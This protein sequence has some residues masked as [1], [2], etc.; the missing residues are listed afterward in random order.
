MKKLLSL[1]VGLLLIGSTT[2]WAGPDKVQ[3]INTLLDDDPT[4]ITGSWNISDAEEV[5]VFVDYDETEV[6]NLVSASVS[7][8]VSHD[9]TNWIDTKFYD[10]TGGT[11]LQTSETLSGDSNYVLWLKKD[12]YHPYIRVSVS[13]TNTDDDDTADIDAYVYILK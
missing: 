1:I 10:V 6:G 11:T 5:A 12:W 3:I 2:V 7:V 13:G 9:N 8:D 4:S